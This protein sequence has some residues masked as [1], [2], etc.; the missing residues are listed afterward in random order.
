MHFYTSAYEAA[1]PPLLVLVTFVGIRLLSYWRSFVFHSD[2]YRHTATVSSEELKK[3]PLPYVKVQITT[4][5][6]AAST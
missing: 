5:G 4:R 6:S 3:V 2:R 1:G